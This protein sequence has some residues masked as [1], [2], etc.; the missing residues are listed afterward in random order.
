MPLS[1]VM[2]KDPGPK[3]QALSWDQMK[4]WN[5]Y[6]DKNPGKPVD[7]IFG[8]MA[9]ENPDA[10][11]G[12]TVEKLKGAFE[13]QSLRAYDKEM[14]DFQRKKET[15]YFDSKEWQEMKA[16][17]YSED[18]TPQYRS[19]NKF[20]PAKY[21]PAKGDGVDLGLT[22]EFGE[23]ENPSGFKIQGSG[24]LKGDISKNLPDDVSEVELADDHTGWVS[25]IDPQEGRMRYAKEE[26]V[27]KK[28]GDKWYN[29]RKAQKDQAAADWE[30]RKA[31]ILEEQRKKQGL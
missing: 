4:L 5:K 24:P 25:W 31:Q 23:F 13:E 1:D 29:K 17:G 2:G 26:E 11:K 16:K 14:R 7:E 20:L 22:N 27:Q 18:W 30:K 12:L 10:V 28:F 19:I 15:G 9:K 3:K 8:M 6:A 21:M